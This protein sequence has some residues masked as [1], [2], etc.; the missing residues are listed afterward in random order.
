MVRFAGFRDGS[1]GRFTHTWVLALLVVPTPKLHTRVKSFGS[2]RE[3]FRISMYF[4]R[5]N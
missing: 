5:L 2:V 4:I 3:I 1:Q